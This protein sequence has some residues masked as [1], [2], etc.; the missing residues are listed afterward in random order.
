MLKVELEEVCPSQPVSSQALASV[1]PNTG[2]R[3]LANHP[4]SSCS[5]LF[6][7]TK[8]AR[9]LCG[10]VGN[11]Q[12]IP[13]EDENNPETAA[14][15][16]LLCK[17][18]SYRIGTILFLLI[19][20]PFFPSD[21]VAWA[22]YRHLSS[23]PTHPILRLHGRSLRSQTR[24]SLTGLLWKHISFVLSF[25]PPLGY[26]EKITVPNLAHAAV[27]ISS[28]WSPISGNCS[29]NANKLHFL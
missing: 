17:Y 26:Y 22:S 7:T 6:R 27:I 24:V 2:A 29:A 3:P 16:L 13:T 19:G 10:K 8:I 4:R 9:S 21:Q 20:D 14:A 18:L 11:P 1:P 12:R 15:K 5:W 23:L 28:R 25:L